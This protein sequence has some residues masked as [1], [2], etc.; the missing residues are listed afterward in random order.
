[1]TQIAFKKL[2][3]TLLLIGTALLLQACGAG[4]TV[5]LM[6]LKRNAM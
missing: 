2:S 6:H 5:V 3:R 4:R 1:M